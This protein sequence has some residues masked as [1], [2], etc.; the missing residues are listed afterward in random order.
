MPNTIADS[1]TFYDINKLSAN[2]INETMVKMESTKKGKDKLANVQIIWEEITNEN[3][4]LNDLF[5]SHELSLFCNRTTFTWYRF[6]ALTGLKDL[7]V[8]THTESDTILNGVLEVQDPT[9]EPEL[10]SIVELPEETFGQ[11]CYFLRYIYQSGLYTVPTQTG[12]VQYKK[13]SS[14]TVFVDE[15]NGIVEVRA[16]SPIGKKIVKQINE[17]FEDDPSATNVDVLSQHDDNIKNL[18]DALEGRLIESIGK[19]TLRLNELTE[20]QSSAISK[21]LMNID[22][23][24]SDDGE[25]EL[26]QAITDARELLSESNPEVPFLAHILSGLGQVSMGVSDLGG[27]SQTLLGNPLYETLTPH[28][29]NDGGYVTFSAT[30]N[31]LEENHTFLV[32][33]GTKSVFIPGNSNELAVKV[34]RDAVTTIRDAVTV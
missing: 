5:N 23:R 25:N 14:L 6:G 7:I 12:N 31:G 33:V 15:I 16:K 3:Q 21:I 11:D 27:L 18:A 1:L 17:Y 32:G 22:L 2:V 4:S 9:T 24:L 29:I 8:S 13:N 30:C 28:L 34:I 26:E 20:Q 10:I 19:P